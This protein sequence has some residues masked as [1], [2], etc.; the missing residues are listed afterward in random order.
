MAN[1]IEKN[2]TLYRYPATL[3]SLKSILKKENP[4]V[5]LPKNPTLPLEVSG[6]TLLTP[7][8]SDKPVGDVVKEV[9]PVKSGEAWVQQWDTRGFNEA[10]LESQAAKDAAALKLSGVE[11]TDTTGANAGPVMCS[12]TKEDMWGLNSVNTSIS[13]GSPSENFWFDNGNLLVLTPANAGE[14]MSVWAP[15]RRSFF[16]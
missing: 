5:I 6:Y 8:P 15:F 9:A 14:F 3:N 7:I 4:S 1:M 16:E 11:Y 10:E 2:G 12:A 13:M